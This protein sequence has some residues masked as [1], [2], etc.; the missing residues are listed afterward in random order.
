MSDVWDLVHTERAALI[1][2]LEL[3]TDEQWARPSLCSAWSVHDVA[4]HLVD[5]AMA[6]PFGVVRAMV[7]ARFDFDRQNEQG[8]RRQRGATPRETLQRLRDVAAR[9]SGP[10]APVDSRLVEEVLH[11]EDIRRPLG[12]VR[13]YDPEAVGRALHYQARTSSALGGGR[14]LAEKAAWRATDI[15]LSFGTGPEVAGPALSLL[16]VVSGR[17]VALADLAGPGVPAVDLD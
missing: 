7:R 2:D 3:L 10:P 17:R 14:Q 6:T 16:M 15:D 12:L 11:G 4:A 8:M 5:N 9:T 1:A 13:H